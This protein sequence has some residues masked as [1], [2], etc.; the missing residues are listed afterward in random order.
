MPEEPRRYLLA[1]GIAK[2]DKWPPLNK[3]SQELERV[4]TLLTGSPYKFERI[5]EKVSDAPHAEDLLTHLAEWAN[6]SERLPTDQ[7]V[8][9]WTSHGEAADEKLHLILG[10]SGALLTKTILVERLVESALPKQSAGGGILLL[11]DVCYSGHGAIDVG[12][13]LGA[14][15]R[16][17]STA[18]MPDIVIL[19]ASRPRDPA[20]QNA[21]SEAFTKAFHQCE[22]E[23]QEHEPQLSLE[24]LRD[25]L[26]E[27]MPEE[28]TPVLFILF[29]QQIK[30]R[31][32]ANPKY[33][34]DPSK[35]R[36]ALGLIGRVRD[37]ERLYLIGEE[38]I[39]EPF[40]GRQP[41]IERLDRW[42][43]NSSTDSHFI[44]TA[45]IGRGKS[46][47]L[48][49]WIEIPALPR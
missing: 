43:G 48:V 44:V 31:F 27:I 9:Y 4:V 12:Q 33:Q 23:A 47:L 25:Y 24:K 16:S 2:Y 35:R 41:E 49:R 39:P 22:Q 20:W 19:S 21:F 46:A 28:Q 45:P 37:F 26:V 30:A 6:A 1:V 32:F 29:N 11:L 17:R 36:D 3:V 13:R 10:N 34:P 7:L 14:I 42:L 18:N 8:I 40:G 15:D 38:G 5:L